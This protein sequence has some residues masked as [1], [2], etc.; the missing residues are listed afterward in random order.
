MTY[1]Q[2]ALERAIA[3]RKREEARA[4]EEAD[5]TSPSH[6]RFSEIECID[7]IRAQLSDEAFMGYLQGNVTKYLW[8]WRLKGG[9]EDLRKAAWYLQRLEE[10]L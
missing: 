8:R 5:A 3:E 4:I 10:S 7:A 6:Y 2:H 1:V 9:R